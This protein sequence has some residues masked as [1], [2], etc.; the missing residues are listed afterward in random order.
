LI[1]EVNYII[2][3]AKKSPRPSFSQKK[4]VRQI[5][6]GPISYSRTHF[7]LILLKSAT[8]RA[9]FLIYEDNF[10]FM[11]LC[12]KTNSLQI[13]I[14]FSLQH[15][16]NL[17]Q[18]TKDTTTETKSQHQQQKVTKQQHGSIFVCT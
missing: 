9:S 18:T 14:I 13:M 17:K 15:T 12:K 4:S 5:K 7:K 11:D 10:L 2:S 6:V 1:P 16:Q 3:K 8:T